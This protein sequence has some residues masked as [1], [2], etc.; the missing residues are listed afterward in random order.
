MT[1]RVATLNVW[2]RLGPWEQRLP[3]IRKGIQELSP[4]LMGVQEVIRMDGDIGGFDQLAE[5][6]NGLGYQTAYGRAAGAPAWV[7][8]NAILSRWPILQSL[9]LPLP[10]TDENRCVVYALVDSPH[11]RIPFFTTHLNW[12][13]HEGHVRQKQVRAL[14]NLVAEHAPIS[15]FPPII[16]GD[17]NAGPEADE[18]RFM[19]GHTGLGGNCVYFADC[20]GI[21][22]EGPG[23]TFTRRNP[24]SGQVKEPN[25]R[26]DYIFVRGPDDKGRGEPLSARVAFDQPTGDVWPSDHFGVFATISA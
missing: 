15:G 8:G 14:A 26:I 20:F 13:L 23:Y 9:V 25:R 4:D 7:N 19:N 3:L 2:N 6:A 16:T 17:F 24:Y 1:L 18:I 5:I 22:G 12:M 11:G 10:N 21:T